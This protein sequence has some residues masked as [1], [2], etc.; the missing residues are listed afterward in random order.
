MKSSYVLILLIIGIVILHAIDDRKDRKT[1][2]NA[3]K[4]SMVKKG[5]QTPSIA[6]PTVVASF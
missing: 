5:T 2:K 6:K 1:E 3:K 4:A